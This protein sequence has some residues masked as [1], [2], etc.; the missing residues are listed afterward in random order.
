VLCGFS[1]QFFP[2]LEDALGGFR[3]VLKHGGTLAVS[4]WGDDDPA[5]DWF[6]DLRKQYGAALKLS[7]NSLD[8]PAKLEAALTQAGFV[9]VSVTPQV[10]EEIYAD[11]EEWWNVEWS[12]SGR[13]GLERIGADALQRFKDVAFA[14]MQ[15]QRTPDGFPYKLEAFAATARAR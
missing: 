10:V 9:D 15:R 2:H 11:E 13:E 4:T 12:I 3:R 7:T 6:A 5:W 8:T 14:A 1:L